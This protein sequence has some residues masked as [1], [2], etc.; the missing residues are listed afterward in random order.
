MLAITVISTLHDN[1]ANRYRLCFIADETKAYGIKPVIQGHKTSRRQNQDLSL[2]LF[3]SKA[4]ML[5]P[6]FHVAA[7]GINN[8]FCL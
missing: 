7:C 1:P 8:T 6:L 4:Q 3:I 2:D 5:S